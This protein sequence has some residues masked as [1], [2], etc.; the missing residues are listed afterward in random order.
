MRKALLVVVSLLAALVLAA[1]PARAVTENFT[2]NAVGAY[3]T[4][5]TAH[6]S[7]T[8]ICDGGTG[9][10]TFRAPAAAPYAFTGEAGVVCDGAS[11]EWSATLIGGPFQLGGGYVVIGTLVA[12]GQTVTRTH[13]VTLR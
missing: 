3:D 12:D 7:G 8:A 6:I 4:D 1:S 10:I 5:A 9:T 11:H 13:K 2:V